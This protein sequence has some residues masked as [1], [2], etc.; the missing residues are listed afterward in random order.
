VCFCEDGF[1][2]VLENNSGVL[3]V[4]GGVGGDIKEGLNAGRRGEEETHKKKKK[5]KRESLM[6]LCYVTVE[7]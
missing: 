3:G 2:A 5:R 7:R 6:M 4:G 1:K